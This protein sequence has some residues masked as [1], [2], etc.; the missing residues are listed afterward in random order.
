MHSNVWNQLSFSQ[1][2]DW[3]FR[4]ELVIEEFD[5]QFMACRANIVTGTGNTV[6]KA[7][8]ADSAFKTEFKKRIKAN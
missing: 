7:K 2:Y 5:N 1:Q 4:H 6:E 8:E 3:T